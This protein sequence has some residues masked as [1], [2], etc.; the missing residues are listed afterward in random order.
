MTRK[1]EQN[2]SPQ[3]N[4]R[5][6]R[7]SKNLV[8]GTNHNYKKKEQKMYSW[9]KHNQRGN[10]KLG[11]GIYQDYNWEKIVWVTTTKNKKLVHGMIHDYE[12]GTKFSQWNKSN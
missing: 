9:N 7:R 5:L 12:E 11:R 10:K 1:K 8:H 6:Q 2:I 4:S 3:N